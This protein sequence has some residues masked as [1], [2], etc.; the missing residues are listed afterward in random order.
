M[1]GMKQG[2]RHVLALLTIALLCVLSAC[3]QPQ[4]PLDYGDEV[5]FE[6]DLNEGKNLE[7]KT[8]SF[9]AAELHPQSLYGYSGPPCH[10]YGLSFSARRVD[11]RYH[12]AGVVKSPQPV[13]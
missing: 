13:G 7:G 11:A 4:I 5:A 9:T 12:R 3:G 2:K 10:S 6:A 8:V 1:Q